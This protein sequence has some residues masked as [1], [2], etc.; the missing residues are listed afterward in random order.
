MD[1]LCA[2][3]VREHTAE[4]IKTMAKARG[5]TVDHL[6]NELMN[7]GRMDSFCKA[8]GTNVKAVNLYEHM[9]K[10]HPKLLTVKL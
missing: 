3:A 6:I 5:L 2:L 9:N 8:C 4:T 7:P 1:G 10:V